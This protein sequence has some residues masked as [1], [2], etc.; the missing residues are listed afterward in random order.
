MVDMRSAWWVRP[1]NTVLDLAKLLQI[2]PARLSWSSLEKTARRRSGVSAELD[3]GFRTE[4]QFLLDSFVSHGGLTALGQIAIRQMILRRLTTRLRLAHELRQHPEIED[5]PIRRPLFIV[6]LPRTGTTLLHR[7]LNCDPANRAPLL[8]QLLTPLTLDTSQTEIQN[9]IRRA[10]RQVRVMVAAAPGLRAI[11]DLDV[12]QPDEC[13]FLLPHGPVYHAICPIPQYLQWLNRRDPRPDY[14]YFKRQ[15]QVLQWRQ[16]ERRWVL[17]SPLHLGALDALLSVFP[18]ARIIQTHRAPATVLASLCSM[19]ETG[20]LVTNRRIDRT[21]IGQDLLAIWSAAMSRAVQVRQTAGQHC[22]IDVRYNQLTADPIDTVE[23]VYR[24]FGESLSPEGRGRMR[25]YLDHDRH[26][27]HG[28]HQYSLERYG[29]NK[30]VVN[31]AFADYHT[32]F[33]I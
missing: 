19:V 32:Y 21:Q 9:R 2:D 7:L 12:H 16:P 6:G 10:Q 18:D 27:T 17:K 4:M 15:L 31:R 26:S 28:T 20:A 33:D 25:G 22:F 29:L 3:D 14:Q 23:N 5:V 30:S 24:H 1:L 11:H 8:W 13:Q